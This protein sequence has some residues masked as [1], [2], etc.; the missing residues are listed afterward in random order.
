MDLI[1]MNML[2]S[3]KSSLNIDEHKNS[4]KDDNHI[5]ENSNN[6]IL[7]DGDDTNISNDSIISYKFLNRIEYHTKNTNE[8]TC[9][10]KYTDEYEKIKKEIDSGVYGNVKMTSSTLIKC[11]KQYDTATSLVWIYKAENKRILQE[12]EYY[13]KKKNHSMVNSLTQL[14]TTYKHVISNISNTVTMIQNSI[15]DSFNSQTGESNNLNDEVGS[16]TEK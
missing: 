6:I 7:K 2:N 16:I 1:S 15:N 4:I 11:Q 3:Y 10:K 14:S 12:I 13:K 9:I 8:V 5:N